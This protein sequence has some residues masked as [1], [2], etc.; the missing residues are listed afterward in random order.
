MKDD[1]EVSVYN[2]CGL[3]CICLIAPLAEELLF[4]GVLLKK[5]LEWKSNPCF[6]IILS[7]AIFALFHLNPAQ[8]PGAFLLGLVMGYVV[9]KTGCIFIGIVIHSISN[10]LCCVQYFMFGYNSKAL[11]FFDGNWMIYLMFIGIS[12][13]GMYF[14][15]KKINLKVSLI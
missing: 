14:I 10:S 12:L 15:L 9:Y 13:W 6:A 8:I 7:S 3:I 2:P 4:R 5:L 1:I 11:A